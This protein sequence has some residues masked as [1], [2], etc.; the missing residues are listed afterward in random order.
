VVYKKIGATI[1]NK[2]SQSDYLKYKRISNQLRIDNQIDSGMTKTNQSPIFTSTN[3]LNYKQYAL[4][5]TIVNTKKTLN[6]LTLNEN[7]R[8]YDMDKMVSGCP[9]FIV[10]KDTQDRANRVLS[11]GVFFDPTKEDYTTRGTP[12]TIRTYWDNEPTN[13]KTECNCAPGRRITDSK[14]CACKTGR[15]GIVR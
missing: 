9:T 4:N 1:Y 7:Q 3:L 10:C 6:K 13:L 12:V 5:N 14:L 15:F 11:V 8:I 2:M